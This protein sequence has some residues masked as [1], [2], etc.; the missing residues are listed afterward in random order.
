MPDDCREC[1]SGDWNAEIGEGFSVGIPRV[2]SLGQC[3]IAY[4]C[5][6]CG[7]KSPQ[8]NS[9]PFS[10]APPFGAEMLAADPARPAAGG[11]E[12]VLLD[13]TTQISRIFLQ[14][15]GVRGPDGWEVV[16][17]SEP[18]I[19]DA[20]MIDRHG[21]PDLM[22]DFA[23]EYLDQF[24]MLVPSGRL[25][26]T[27][28]AVMPA[29]LLLVVSAE[30]A[31]KAF[32]IRSD[33]SQPPSHSLTGLYSSLRAEHRDEAQRRFATSPMAGKLAEAGADPPEIEAILGQSTDT[34]EGRSS[35]FS[36]ATTSR[37]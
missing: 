35:V 25:P 32:R 16:P 20:T 31:M 30:L 33:G 37:P 2:A 7:A 1:G 22:A 28:R 26:H 10:G 13:G 11:I 17:V 21:D 12:S 9:I 23:E 6:R 19:Q 29:L 27:I 5:S 24:W 15:P 18:T 8:W 3:D 4:R 14:Y 34:Y 36:V